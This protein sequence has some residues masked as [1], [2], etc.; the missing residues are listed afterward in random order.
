MQHHTKPL[1]L[2][3]PQHHNRGPH[4]RKPHHTNPHTL[5]QTQP[6]PH[7]TQDRPAFDLKKPLAAWN[8]FLALFS[9]VGV[10]RTVPYLLFWQAF[11]SMI[12]PCPTRQRPRHCVTQ[13]STQY[14][15]LLDPPKSINHRNHPPNSTSTDAI[16]NRLANLSFKELECTLPVMTH[17]DRD[18]GLWVMLFTISKVCYM[19]MHVAGSVC[20]VEGKGGRWWDLVGLG[21][22]A[23]G[24]WC[25]ALDGSAVL[26]FALTMCFPLCNA[27]RCLS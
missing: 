13:S 16:R 23:S 27:R 9:W 14:S 18:V 12:G 24:V 5:T 4:T 7:T 22:G 25:V 6:Q 17:G 11:G 2:T 15:T 20:S 10:V 8:L 1:T 21:Q 19:H 3:R 26:T